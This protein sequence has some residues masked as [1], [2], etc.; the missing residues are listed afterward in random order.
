MGAV[1]EAQPRSAERATDGGLVPG[2]QALLVEHGPERVV[3]PAAVGQVGD[4]EACVVEARRLGF[5]NGEVMELALVHGEGGGIERL[6]LD[7]GRPSNSGPFVVGAHPVGASEAED[8]RDGCHVGQ[9][10][11]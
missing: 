3:Q 6:G 4:R 11:R 7:G 5:E 1:A 10:A 2:A 9:H 8:G